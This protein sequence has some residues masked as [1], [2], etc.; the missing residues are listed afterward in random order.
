MVPVL[1][2]VSLSLLWLICPPPRCLDSLLSI[3]DLYLSSCSKIILAEYC[4][5]AISARNTVVYWL[6]LTSYTSTQL[7]DYFSDEILDFSS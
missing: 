7:Y 2:D 3:M 1:E 4:M 6:K 5:A